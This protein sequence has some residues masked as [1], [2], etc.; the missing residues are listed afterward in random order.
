[1]TS[2]SPPSTASTVKS[3]VGVPDAVRAMLIE[4][5]AGNK[6]ELP[7]LPDVASKVVQL[8]SDPNADGRTLAQLV[9]RDAAIAGHL[10]RLANSPLYAPP[11]PLVSLDQV[12]SRLG[13]KKIREI[14]LII[15]CQSKVFAVPGFEHTVKMLFR[16][17]LAAGAFAQEIAR[18]RRW[19]VEEGFLC[20]LL[21]DVGRPVLIQELVDLHA[22]ANCTF[23]YM[24]CY[25]LITSLHARL[26]SALVTGWK[27][28]ARLGE[29]ILHHHTPDKSTTAA[30]TAMMTNLADDLAHWLMPIDGERRP[31][32]D[33]LREHPMLEP[34]N[35]YP[36]EMDALIAQKA[37]ISTMVNALA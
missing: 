33:Q 11:T 30:Q 8:C 34:L 32:E 24:A 5:I 16:H 6:L 28:P 22:K 25:P 27:L 21:H 26:G 29:T 35:I 14:A 37:K 18:S 12:I 2:T 10:M 9:Q 3:A 23:D 7:V 13:I 17:S 20:G 36:E 19:N 15:S 1:M 31:S 4:R